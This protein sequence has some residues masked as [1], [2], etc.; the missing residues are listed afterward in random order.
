MCSRAE[1][2]SSI[3][4]KLVQQSCNHVFMSRNNLAARY[5]E[6]SWNELEA[7]RSVTIR[8]EIMVKVVFAKDSEGTSS[9][10]APSDDRRSYFK[11]FDDLLN[12]ICWR[13]EIS[14][15]ARTRELPTTGS[16]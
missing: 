3:A 11:L 15:D 8:R 7:R 1:E 9:L 2:L 4:P 10:W 16:S 13:L 5:E 14:D 6:S 12:I